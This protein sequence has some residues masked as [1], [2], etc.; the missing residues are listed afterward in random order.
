MSLLRSKCWNKKCAHFE[1]GTRWPSKWSERSLKEKVRAKG[2]SRI[3]LDGFRYLVSG[4]LA[5]GADQERA[6]GVAQLVDQ[7]VERDAVQRQALGIVAVCLDMDERALDHAS[8]AAVRTP[9]HRT[10]QVAKR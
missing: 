1:R 7:L 5:E 9:A 10:R 2:F 4:E 6:V 8:A 3:T